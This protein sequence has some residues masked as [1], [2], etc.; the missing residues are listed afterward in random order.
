MKSEVILRMIGFFFS[1]SYDLFEALS[2]IVVFLLIELLKIEC[3]M[4]LRVDLL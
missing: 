3:N 1:S 2:K 4:K